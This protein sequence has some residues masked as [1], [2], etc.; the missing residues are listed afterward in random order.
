MP[1]AERIDAKEFLEEFSYHGAPF[2]ERWL[3]N[4]WRRKEGKPPLHARDLR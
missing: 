3:I 4:R 1:M 2:W